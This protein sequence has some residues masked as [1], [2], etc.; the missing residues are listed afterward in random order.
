[1]AYFYVEK[2]NDVN[3]VRL[4]FNEIN[5]TEREELKKELAAAYVPGE[6]RF[7]FNLSKIGFL[8]SL[9][10]ATMLFFAKT[11]REQGGDV[12]L[13]EAAE[14]AK[15]VIKITLLDKI[16]EIYETEKEAIRSF[17]EK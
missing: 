6:T 1:M 3:V 8:S 16:F 17:G 4:S 12:K 14:S 2:V 9:V 13:C 7:V 5:F 10:I 11:V 15:Y